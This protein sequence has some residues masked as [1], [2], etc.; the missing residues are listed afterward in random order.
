[1]EELLHVRCRRYSY[2]PGHTHLTRRRHCRYLGDYPRF[3]SNQSLTGWMLLSLYKQTNA[4]S[5][6]HV[7]GGRS[8]TP[9]LAVDEDIRTSFL[10]GRDGTAEHWLRL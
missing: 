4:S 7:A 6:L 3:A 5:T 8:H 2:S 9:A 10:R 1:V